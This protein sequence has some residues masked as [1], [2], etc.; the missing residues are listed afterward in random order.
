[1][2]SYFLQQHLCFFHFFLKLSKRTVYRIRY[3]EKDYQV[4]LKQGETLKHTIFTLLIRRRNLIQLLMQLGNT[5]KFYQKL[6]I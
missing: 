2:Q 1:M 4:V 6:K 3:L 5:Q